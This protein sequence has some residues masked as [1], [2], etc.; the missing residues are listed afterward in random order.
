ML[1]RTRI[2]PAY[3]VSNFFCATQEGSAVTVLLE[4]G[5]AG[6]AHQKWPPRA[7]SEA[8]PRQ[9][10]LTIYF[11]DYFV[12]TLMPLGHRDDLLTC[13]PRAAWAVESLAPISC[14]SSARRYTATRDIDCWRWSKT[15]RNV[16]A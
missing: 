16:N 3:E 14:S 4:D 9:P 12:T 10:N 13:T 1:V 15:E 8:G 5:V 7:A 6:E 11:G 2:V